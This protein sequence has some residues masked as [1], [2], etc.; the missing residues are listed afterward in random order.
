MYSDKRLQ[1]GVESLD[2]WLSI[3]NLQGSLVKAFIDS[4]VQIAYQHYPQ[5]DCHSNSGLLQY[6]YHSHR[7]N[8]EHG[9]IHVYVKEN[10]EADPIH[11]VAIGLSDKGLPISLFTVTSESVS[12]EL[13]DMKLLLNDATLALKSTKTENKL[14]SYISTFCLFYFDDIKK[15]IVQKYY[16]E[17]RAK[18]SNDVLSF[19][20]IDWSD[21]LDQA[22]K[23][24]QIK[25][26]DPS[27]M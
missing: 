26:R 7:E 3:G 5:Q 4:D 14:T 10:R 25:K 23:N 27:I 1:Y 11:L 15:L 17:S 12:E 22:E 13:R 24:C 16:H 18:F 19:M 2:H 21:D 9:H 20:L 8:G 6:F